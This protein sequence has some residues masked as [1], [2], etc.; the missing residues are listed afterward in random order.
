MARP[1]TEAAHPVHDPTHPDDDP[2]SRAARAGDEGDEAGDGYAA[3]TQAVGRVVAWYSQ[4]ILRERSA[5][6]PDA[7]RIERLKA[8]Q[9][10]AVADQRALI[11]AGPQETARI[12]AL[13][14]A[15]LK[16]LTQP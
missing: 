8:D 7:E 4:E 3:A 9:R 12:T 13:Y 11:E 6:R 2:D 14:E 10:A 5:A 1:D 15:R 16:D